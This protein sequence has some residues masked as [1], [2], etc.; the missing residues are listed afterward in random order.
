MVEIKAKKK[1]PSPHHHKSCS[2]TAVVEENKEGSVFPAQTKLK[3]AES[4]AVA[5]GG[6]WERSEWC[7]KSPPQ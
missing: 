7:S 6:K 2:V 3:I 4:L 1:K 5:D